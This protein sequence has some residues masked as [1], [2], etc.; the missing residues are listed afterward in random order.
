M[1]KCSRSWH[2]K[3]KLK[4]LKKQVKQNDTVPLHPW[5]TFSEWRRKKNVLKYEENTLKYQEKTG[6]YTLKKPWIALT[7]EIGF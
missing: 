1:K 3:K 5:E 2:L 6:K 7:K 4:R